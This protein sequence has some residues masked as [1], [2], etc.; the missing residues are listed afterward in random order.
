MERTAPNKFPKKG[1]S[2]MKRLLALAMTVLAVGSSI[3]AA[4][5]I[6]VTIDTSKQGQI[7]TQ[8]KEFRYSQSPRD[9]ATGQ[10]SGRRMTRQPNEPIV[11]VKDADKTSQFFAQAAAKGELLPAV[12]FEF[13]RRG[14]DGKT[15]VYQT[16][17]LT[18]ALISSVK[19]LNGDRPMLEISFTF[20][21]IEYQHKQGK[22]A[23]TDSWV[24]RP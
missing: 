13:T 14:G 7:K 24:L 4:T 2:M 17:R 6:N 12:L 15:E 3:L 21:K 22:N 5:D 8:A 19:T 10:T 9:I 18:N 16:V 11:I 23:A 20:Q 1:V